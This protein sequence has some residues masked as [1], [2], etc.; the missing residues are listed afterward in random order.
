MP[1]P[2]Y[3]PRERVREGAALA[4]ADAALV[5]FAVA[6]KVGQSALDRLRIAGYEAVV[7]VPDDPLPVDDVRRRHLVGLEAVGDLALAVVRDGQ[8]PVAARAQELHDVL[9]LLIH[10]HGE[11]LHAA[12]VQ[13]RGDVVE[14]RQ[15]L[16]AGY[17]PRRP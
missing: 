7:H 17:A 3:G 8:R 14:H 4:R 6:G 1:G 10:G 11:D 9:A 13:A 5:V 12:V 2:R 16:L 15:L